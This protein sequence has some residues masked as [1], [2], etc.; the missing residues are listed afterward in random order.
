[1]KLMTKWQRIEYDNTPIYVR[2]D[3]PDWFVPNQAADKALVE[4]WGNGK[5]SFDIKDLLKRIDGPAGRECDE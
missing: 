4:L 3:V 5:T 2:P 1:M